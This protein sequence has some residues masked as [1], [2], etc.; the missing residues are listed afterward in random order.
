MSAVR[1]MDDRHVV[2]RWRA[3]QRTVRNGELGTLAATGENFGDDAGLD[4]SDKERLRLELATFRSHGG[5]YQASDLLS[6]ALEGHLAAT[7]AVAVAQYL[8]ESA[9]PGETTALGRAANEALRRFAGNKRTT[10]GSKF[11]PPPPI[12]PR[13]VVRGARGALRRSPRNAVAWT[14]LALA[15]TEMGELERAHRSIETAVALAPRNRF[16]VR[17]AARFHLHV[18]DP[19]HARWVLNAADRWD[20]PWVVSADIAVASILGT[21]PR[22]FARKAQRL[23]DGSHAARDISE[24]ACG[25]ANLEFSSGNRKSGR[26]LI[27]AGLSD[28]TENAVAQAEFEAQRA[29]FELPESTVAVPGGYEAQ[30]LD[31]SEK[32]DWRAA[33]A[34]AIKWQSDQKFDLDPAMHLSYLAAVGLE[35]FESARTAAETG[36]IANPESSILLNNLAFAA[37]NMGDLQAARNLLERAQQAAELSTEDIVSLEAT[38]GLIHFRSGQAQVGRDLYLRAIETAL[39]VQNQRLAGLA[40]AFWLQEETRAGSSLAAADV[41]GAVNLVRASGE[42][43]AITVLERIGEHVGVSTT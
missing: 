4:A 26:R 42:Q 32:A 41:R 21:A 43:G 28:P 15:Q 23:L 24:L 31:F 18:G 20:D 35:D 1:G 6:Q 34:S 5:K 29:S 9:A 14:D 37:A 36:L 13:D 10:E 25:L 3:F 40:A 39:K 8:L 17:S 12:E 27:T 22:S 30:T 38:E 33:V 19:E 2:P 11:S 16:V 7:D